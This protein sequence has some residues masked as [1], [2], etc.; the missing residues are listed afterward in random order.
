MRNDIQFLR[1]IAVLVVVLY[2]AKILP[3]PGGYLGVDVFFVISG[4]LIT[5]IILRD[6][7]KGCFSFKQF[8]IRRAKRLLPAAYSTLI[9]TTLLSYGFL[10]S[11]QWNDYIEQFI[12]ALT[13]TANLILP[14]QTGYFE[15]SAEEKPLLHIWSLSLEEQYYFFMP[16]FLVCLLKKWRGWF[17]VASILISIMLCF[18]L[19][20]FP[21]TYWRLPTIDSS[22]MGFYLLPAR[23]WELLIGSLVAWVML[24]SPSFCISRVIKLLAFSVL[25]GIIVFP[26]DSIHPRLDA[27]VVVT[28]TAILLLGHDNWLP[29]SFITRS[30]EKV[31]DWSYSLYLLHWP[32]FAFANIAYLEAVPENIMWL[33][34]CFSLIMAFLQY[35][36]VE[37]PFRYGWKA[38]NKKTFRVFVG[39]SIFLILLPIPAVLSGQAGDID[40]K[41]IYRTD[42]TLSEVCSQRH[43]FIKPTSACMT[44]EKPMVALWGDSFAMHLIP[45]LLKVPI[46]G[47]TF[48][49]VT[50]SACAPIRGIASLDENYGESW[51]KTCLDFNE[52][53][54]Q[55]IRDNKSIKIVLL[56]SPFSGY[57]NNDQLKL[58]YK[59]KNIIGKRSV[60]IEQMI[61][62]I[63]GLRRAGKYPII[64]APPPM[65]GFNIGECRERMATNLIVLGQTDCD[66]KVVQ[67]QSHQK[68]IID[69]L[70]EIEQ[71]TDIEVIRFNKLIC[72][73]ET[74]ITKLGDIFVYRDEGHLTITGSEM[75][76]PRLK[77]VDLLIYYMKNTVTIDVDSL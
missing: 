68:G 37:Q 10:T 8:Y 40:F 3:V 9:F 38:S 71:R 28:L 67:Y 35:Q 25:V 66:F 51:A 30:V 47:E 64:V 18:I 4:F 19:V 77:L 17:I 57:F 5:S 69:A 55:Y 32:I 52:K 6:L 12:G 34:F 7:D 70:N 14:F 63:E 75:L 31:G 2:H 65:P 49:Q 59:G 27:L 29:L 23:A 16:L 50:K 46:I 15:A 20:S 42:A 26:V 24:Q 43:V 36:Y 45:G 22:M 56:S 62:T 44:N 61:E 72:N 1:G 54:F 21:F 74:C 41:D 73:E 76:I 48:V 53:A 11:T 33:L 39:S 60:A 58:F 13:Y